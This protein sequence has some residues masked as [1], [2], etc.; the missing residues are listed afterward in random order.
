MMRR[1]PINASELKKYRNISIGLHLELKEKDTI[2]EIE[3]QLKD[4]VKKFGQLPS[5]LDGHKHM[6]L[7]VKNLP[8]VI[9]IAK[10]Y[11]L[12]L[13][14]YLP[15]DRKIIRKADIVTPDLFISWHPKRKPE[16]WKKLENIKPG[17]TELVCHPG[18]YDKKS[19]SSYNRQREKELKILKSREFKKLLKKYQLINYSQL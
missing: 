12:P 6:H 14:S 18:H 19:K 11:G 13:R 3:S 2:R 5:H 4:F 16:L 8:K 17:T 7:T 9:K 1:N 10:K 15:E